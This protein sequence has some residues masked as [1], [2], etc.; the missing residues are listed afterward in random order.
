MYSTHNWQAMKTMTDSNS[1]QSPCYTTAIQ[2][3]WNTT[4]LF[5]SFSHVL[6]SVHH[7]VNIFNCNSNLVFWGGWGTNI[8]RALWKMHFSIDLKGDQSYR[9]KEASKCKDNNFPWNRQSRESCTS[10]FEQLPYL[11][12]LSQASAFGHCWR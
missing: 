11:F 9:T 4:K 12:A 1:Y 7:D 5:R 2:P 3:P 8:W 6:L 10:K